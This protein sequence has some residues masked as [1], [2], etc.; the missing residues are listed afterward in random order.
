MSAYA[1]TYT[2]SAV[3]AIP[4]F[5]HSFAVTAFLRS[6]ISRIFFSKSAR[7]AAAADSALSAVLNLTDLLDVWVLLTLPVCG[8]VMVIALLPSTPRMKVFGRTRPVECWN[9]QLDFVHAVPKRHRVWVGCWNV[10]P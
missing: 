6:S 5:P 1:C 10:H 3:A 7:A 8:A 9:V 4:S 2:Q